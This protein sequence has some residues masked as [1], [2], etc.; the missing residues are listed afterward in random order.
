MNWLNDSI[1][2][3]TLIGI[4]AVIVITVFVVGKYVRQ[5]KTDSSTGELAKEKWDG[6]GEY[7]NELPIGWALSFFG[8]IIYALWYFLA[9]YP[10]AAYSQIGEYNQEVN[11]HSDRF[12]SKWSNADEATLQDMGKGI[13]FVQCASCHGVVGDGMDGKAQNLTFWGS[14][15]YI[16]KTIEIGAKGS[17]YPLGE[18]PAGLLDPQSAKAVAAYLV[19]KIAKTG[20][21][22]NP[23][24]VSEGEALWAT[25]AGCH[26]EDGTGMFGM[27]ANLSNYG[28]SEFIV[29]VLNRGKKGMIGNMPAFNDGRL[30]DI[31]KLAV[32]KYVTTLVE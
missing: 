23:T 13:Y 27:S 9:G 8:T 14:E 11:A 28:K 10:L 25:C 6:I 31:Q 17:G 19:E 5:M 15:E 30:T 18:M 7:K 29:E 3:F 32:G 4:G 20:K 1:S 21:S 24:L 26:S 16:V 12:E 2:L 22:K